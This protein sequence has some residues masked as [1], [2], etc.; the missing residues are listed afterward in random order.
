M[1]QNV[2]ELLAQMKERPAMWL[3]TADIS[4]LEAFLNGFGYAQPSSLARPDAWPPL[5][6]L[7]DWTAHKFHQSSSVMG[8]RRILTQHCQGDEQAALRL[9]F[10][11]LEEFKAVRVMRVLEIQLSPAAHAFYSSD[12]CQIQ[13]YAGTDPARLPAPDGVYVVQFSG[14]LGHYVFHHRQGQELSRD[15]SY[16]SLRACL[17]RVRQEF[18][19]T[20]TWQEVGS[21]S[22]AAIRA[23]L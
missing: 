19:D 14:G 5:W 22:M 8:W 21:L 13:R 6:L 15:G 4:L 3:G 20:S 2:Y 17:K 16:P 10:D 1:E 7:H 12:A 23:L 18:G 11:V 9:F